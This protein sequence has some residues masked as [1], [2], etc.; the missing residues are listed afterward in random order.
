MHLQVI[1]LRKRPYF[2]KVS[3]HEVV[4]RTRDLIVAD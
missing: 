3:G 1:K 2:G 4:V